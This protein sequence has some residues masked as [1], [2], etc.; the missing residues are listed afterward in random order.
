LRLQTEECRNVY[1]PVLLYRSGQARTKR[2]IGDLRNSQQVGL[3]VVNLYDGKHRNYT[4]T[5]KFRPG[6]VM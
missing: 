2:A 6:F 3:G 1:V 5:C 4:N